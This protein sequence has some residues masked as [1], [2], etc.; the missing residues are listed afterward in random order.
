MRSSGNKKGKVR[1]D[2][3]E[4]KD[5]KDQLMINIRR[6]LPSSS[7]KPFERAMRYSY[8]QPPSANR[9]ETSHN[10]TELKHSKDGRHNTTDIFR[11]RE[12]QA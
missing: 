2:S 1:L 12:T 5:V 11:D 4:I 10:S 6:R 3:S 7:F 8:I 9:A